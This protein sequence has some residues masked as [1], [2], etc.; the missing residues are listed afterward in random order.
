MLKLMTN[1]D[2]MVVELK[3]NVIRNM[4]PKKEVDNLKWLSDAIIGRLWISP[5]GLLLYNAKMKPR[6]ETF[7]FPVT[8]KSL[9]EKDCNVCVDLLFNPD[10][11]CYLLCDYYL[12]INRPTKNENILYYKFFDDTESWTRTHERGEAT[13]LRLIQISGDNWL[14]TK[15]NSKSILSIKVTIVDSEYKITVKLISLK[16]YVGSYPLNTELFI[17]K[18]ENLDNILED[19]EYNSAINSYSLNTKPIN[20][21]DEIKIEK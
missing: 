20:T 2:E 16:G 4:L 1:Y 5:N 17:K 18:N 11:K 9:N 8:R 14:I 19:S 7:K 13:Q 12:D 3:K 15:S 6:I 10:T 21:L